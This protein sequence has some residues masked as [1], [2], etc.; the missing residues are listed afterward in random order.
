MTTKDIITEKLTEAFA[1]ERLDVIDESHRHAGHAG[2][3]ALSAVLSYTVTFWYAT[4]IFAVS[5][6]VCALILNSG[7]PQFDPDA[8]PVVVG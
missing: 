2:A 7:V 8:E 3:Q 6:V 5:A 1:P 4:V